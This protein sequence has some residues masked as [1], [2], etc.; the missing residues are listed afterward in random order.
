MTY[1]TTKY[2][3]AC[4]KTKD[5][6]EFYSRS[7]H[8]GIGYSGYCKVCQIQKATATTKARRE[9]NRKPRQPMSAE[10]RKKISDMR[11]KWCA[12]N[13]DK[14]PWMVPNG[15]YKS[16]PCELAK[17]YLREKGFTFAE[18]Y[19]P[20]VEGRFFSLDIAF[21]DKKIAIEINGTQHYNPDGTLKPYYQTRHD[22]LERNGW[23]VYE[24]HYSM[25][26][27]LAKLEGMVGEIVSSDKKCEFDY[28]AY[29]PKRRVDKFC[30]C[31]KKINPASTRCRGCY[32]KFK[33]KTVKV[34]M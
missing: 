23:K 28:L 18:E 32:N 25:C 2:C 30:E 7:R 12:E 5:V 19:P 27:H 8:N 11:K 34:D 9:R 13:P 6:S 22:I 24:I 29:V 15:K 3:K 14:H 4:D 31:G 16:G 10:A 26:Y 20:N 21:P 17:K 33:A 1:P